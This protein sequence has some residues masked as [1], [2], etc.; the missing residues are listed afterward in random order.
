MEMMLSSYCGGGQTVVE[1]K[2]PAHLVEHV[3]VCLS[4]LF[5]V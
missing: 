1:V 3:S 5:V 4:V 2:G